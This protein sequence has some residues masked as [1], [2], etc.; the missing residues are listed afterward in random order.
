MNY[1]YGTLWTFW[2]VETVCFPESSW[3]ENEQLEHFYFVCVPRRILTQLQMDI[4]MSKWWQKHH[5]LV[6]LGNAFGKLLQS[7]LIWRL[8]WRLMKIWFCL[9]CHY[10]W[11]GS[12]DGTG[13]LSGIFWQVII[14][15]TSGCRL[16]L[17]TRTKTTNNFLMPLFLSTSHT[18]Y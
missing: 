7:C 3:E 8:T 10:H 4:K 17:E 13:S 6:S 12:G 18:H 11:S 5:I 16:C 14:V 15:F 1:C 9:Q 2:S